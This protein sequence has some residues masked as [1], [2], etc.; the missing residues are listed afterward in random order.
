L[1]YD[2]PRSID[3]HIHSTASDGTWTPQEI[4]AE[5]AVL[6]LGAVAI[7]DHDTLSG[8]K[9]AIESGIPHSIEFLTGIEI[10]SNPPPFSYI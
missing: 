7:T 5:A 3:L 6:R 9:S 8:V 1:G 10:G 4:L 2:C